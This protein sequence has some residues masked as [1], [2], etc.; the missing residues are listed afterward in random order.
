MIVLEYDIIDCKLVSCLWRKY[1]ELPEGAQ[2]DA[3]FGAL[4]SLD[5]LWDSGAHESAI[6]LHRILDREM[7]AV[8]DA[9][10]N[11]HRRSSAKAKAKG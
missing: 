2:S 3:A 5:A 8:I 6:M 4:R 1:W 11:S 9:V 10:R 7:L